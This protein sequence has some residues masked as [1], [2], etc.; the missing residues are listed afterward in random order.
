MSELQCNIRKQRD[1]GDMHERVMG[2]LAVLVWVCDGDS[3]SKWWCEWVI[4][5]VSDVWW[6]EWVMVWVCV[7]V[8]EWFCVSECW[9]ECVL[10]WVSDGVSVCW[11]EWVMVWMSDV[12]WCEW[13]LD[14]WVNSE[15]M[16]LHDRNIMSVWCYSMSDWENKNEYHFYRNY[17][18]RTMG[19]WC[20]SISHREWHTAVQLQSVD[21]CQPQ[22]YT[23]K[24]HSVPRHINHH[25]Y[26]I[27]LITSNHHG[28]LALS[29]SNN[30]II[31][32]FACHL[33]YHVFSILHST[34][35]NSSHV[36]FILY[37]TGKTHHSHHSHITH[38]HHHSL[39][40][41]HT[42]TITHSHQHTLT[43]THTHTITHSHQ[44]TLTP[45]LTH[46]ITHHS[47]ALSLT[48][49]I[50]YSHYHHHTLIPTLLT[51]PSLA[52]ACHHHLFV[53]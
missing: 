19:K 42:H 46:T 18:I 10:V 51:N 48:H 29:H 15:C 43:P 38:S 13:V 53:S 39:T 45:S 1:D 26:C 27:V 32:F 41:T 9:C 47:L 34:M 50:T 35:V 37:F 21:S 52:H 12:W 24:T 8:S 17:H 40:P 6:C 49:T 36:F 30:K 28:L 4:V 33:G 44:H 2:L 3:A 16:K 11:C 25:S 7:G 14:C 31:S 5:R 23:I 22:L 20:H